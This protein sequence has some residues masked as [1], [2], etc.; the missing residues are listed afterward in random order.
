MQAPV[1]KKFDL[2]KQ[3]KK[4]FLVFLLAI[5]VYTGFVFYADIKKVVSV[6]SNFN[7]QIVPILLGL[8]FLNYVL[9]FIRWEYFLKKVSVTLPFGKS[10]L[11]FLSG[12]SMTVTPGKAGEVV[13]AYLV[14]K[15]KGH[16]YSEIVPLIF[17]ERF[18]DGIGMLLIALGGI[19]LFNNRLVTLA[20]FGL[21][22]LIILF[23]FFGKKT[24]IKISTF[25]DRKLKKYIVL[26][27]L[28]RTLKNM[29]ILFSGKSLLVATLISVLAWSLEG[30]SLYLLINSFGPV[31]FLNGLFYSLFIFAFASIAGFLALIPGGV[32]VAEISISSLLN[33]FFNLTVAQAVFIT[34]IFRFATL[35][36]G[37]LIG[38]VSLFFSLAKIP[39]EGLKRL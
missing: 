37:V 18:T 16:R 19:Y 27:F 17:T 7:W 15:E 8:S 28:L 13:K 5:L 2:K 30:Y 14:N 4:I 23:I 25:L 31:P 26:D 35:W 20:F 29:E 1:R 6:A 39:E 24:V 22:A 38:L 34:L 11:F 33:L 3:E 36:F 12:I 9:R 32:G 21:T 10:F